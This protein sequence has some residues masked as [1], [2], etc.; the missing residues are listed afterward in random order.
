MIDL[1]CHILPELDDGSQSLEES[2][3]MARMAVNSGVR[4]MA[5]TPHCMGERAEEVYG[6]WS[7]LR[8]ALEETG[9]PLKLY[10]GME[11]F[12]T[13]DTA[14]LLREGKLFTLNGSRYPL[15]EFAFQSSGEEETLILRS[16]C[17]AGFR[18]LVAHPERSARPGDRQ[19]VVSLG[20]PVSGKPGQPSGA[21]RRTRAGAGLC[22]GGAG[23][24][25]RRG[26]RRPLSPGADALDGG[27]TRSPRAGI[28][29]PVRPGAAAGQPQKNSERR[30]HHSGRT[31]VV[32]MKKGGKL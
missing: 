11:I 3:A 27:C 14:R 1:H 8:Q 21:L 22:A 5:A 30:T 25:R 31:G 17:R 10:P 7:L 24:C 13:P 23:L 9:V 20:L 2:L 29:P 6:T 28:L 26:Q 19:P 12:G 15:I 16:V 32:L 18:P 4:A